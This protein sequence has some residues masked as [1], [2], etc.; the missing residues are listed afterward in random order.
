M[1]K[2]AREIAFK[3]IFQ[4]EFN[5]ETDVE[6]SFVSLV[7]DFNLQHEDKDFA[8]T[9]WQLYTEN[10]ADIQTLIEVNLK[11]YEISRVYKVDLALLKLAVAEIKYYKQTPTPVVINEILDLSKKYSTENSSKF[12]NGVLGAII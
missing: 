9:L 12:L 10:A 4:S 7:E 8:H 1:R 6:L 5:N 11:G 2:D 3:L